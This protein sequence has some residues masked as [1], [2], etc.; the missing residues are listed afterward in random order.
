M[1]RDNDYED[2]EYEEDDWEAPEPDERDED[3]LDSLPCPACG[4][5][6]YAEAEACPYC[7][8][9]VTHST[10]ALAGKPIWFIALAILG[11][12]AAIA[13]ILR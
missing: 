4:E 12:V 10:S 13:S 2:E 8:E 11:I 9:F 6:I 1:D 5:Q 7:G 3:E